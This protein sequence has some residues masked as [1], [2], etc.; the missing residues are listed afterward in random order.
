MDI[1][2]FIVI[3]TGSAPIHD[4]TGEINQTVVCT[5]LSVGRHKCTIR[6]IEPTRT[7]GIQQIRNQTQQR[8]QMQYIARENTISD[9]HATNHYFRS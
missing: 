1:V 5:V 9:A 2:H 3:E 8:K 4:V 6:Y 7:N